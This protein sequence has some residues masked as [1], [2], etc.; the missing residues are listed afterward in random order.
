[1][2]LADGFLKSGFLAGTLTLADPLTPLEVLLGFKTSSDSFGVAVVGALEKKDLM[3]ICLEDEALE[4]CFFKDGGACPGVEVAGSSV[5][6]MV[7][8][9][10]EC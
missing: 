10:P 2:F 3:D 1:M 8:K 6:T 5:F 7:F 4:F 9:A